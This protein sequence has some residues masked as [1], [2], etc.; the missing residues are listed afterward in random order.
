MELLP[1]V[2]LNQSH[3]ESQGSLPDVAALTVSEG[4]C[5]QLE[6]LRGQGSQTLARGLSLWPLKPQVNVHV[7]RKFFSQDLFILQLGNRI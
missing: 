5:H 6:K 4:F 3:S 1:D 7:A 2:C